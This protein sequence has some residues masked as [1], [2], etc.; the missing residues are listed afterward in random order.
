MKVSP[1]SLIILLC[2]LVISVNAIRSITESYN[3]GIVYDAKKIQLQSQYLN[4]IQKKNELD[5]IN[6]PFFAEK[7]LRESLNYYK[8]GERLI[9]FTEKPQSLIVTQETD[10]QKDVARIWLEI[11]INGIQSPRL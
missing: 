1:L 8:P 4:L 5:Y 6:T 9:V 10:T 11:L 3:V 2:C 7:Q